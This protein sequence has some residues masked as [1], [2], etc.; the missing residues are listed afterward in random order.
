VQAR[1]D[2][3]SALLYDAESIYRTAFID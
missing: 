1:E 2:H 3:Y